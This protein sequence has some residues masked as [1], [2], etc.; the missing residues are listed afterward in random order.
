MKGFF[1]KR[2][3]VVPLKERRDVQPVDQPPLAAQI[4]EN[5]LLYEKL[6]ERVQ[7]LERREQ[8]SKKLLH[9]FRF[10]ISRLRKELASA[11]VKPSAVVSVSTPLLESSP[12]IY[13]TQLEEERASLSEP[14]FSD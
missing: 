2:N 6:L 14:D 5:R 9:W 13:E 3:V 10:E 8:T 11:N 12:P 1:E 7:H 4:A